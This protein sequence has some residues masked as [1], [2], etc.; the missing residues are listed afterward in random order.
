[1]PQTSADEA[2]RLLKEGNARYVAGK[3]AR[4]NQTLF[5][6]S[7][8]AKIQNP[9]AVLVGCSDSRVPSEIVFD[10][11]IGDLFVIRTAG[12]RV[13]DLAIAS[14]EYAVRELGVKLAIVLGHDRCGAVTAAINNPQPIEAWAESID[15]PVNHIPRLLTKLQDVVTRTRDLPGDPIENAVLENVR[16]VVRKLA[17]SSSV[18][19]DAMVFDGLKIVGARYQLDTGIIDFIS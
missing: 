13:D 12:H 15:G 8:V 16:T 3:P 2:V 4:P 10:L 1:M 5:R 11:G 17:D 9:F 18:L 14:V 6:R 19:Q 7:E